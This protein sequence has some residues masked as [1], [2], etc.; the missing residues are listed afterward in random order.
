M[1]AVVLLAL[2]ALPL[3]AQDQELKPI[4]QIQG[5]EEYK[6]P[7]GL[8]IVLVPDATKPTL[9]MNLTV[10]VG[11]VH[12][13]GGEAGMAHVFEHILFHSAEGFPDITETLKNLGANY[14]GS[15]SYERTN[16]FET[17]NATD[18][19]LETVIKL[20]AARLSKADLKPEDLEKEGKIVENEFDIGESSPQGLLFKAFMGAMYDYHNYGR[21]PIGTVDDFRALKIDAIRAFYK[22]YYRPDNAVVI[23]TGKFERAKALGLI[24]KHFG[25][26]K[27]TGEGRPVYTTREP[28]ARGERRVTVRKT[29]DSRLVLIGYRIPGASSPESPVATVLGNMLASGKTGPLYEAVVGKGLAASL[30]VGSYDLRTASPFLGLAMLPKDKDPDAVESTM[31]EYFEKKIDALTQADLDRAKSTLDRDFDELLNDPEALGTQLSEYE[32]AGS[33]KI[34]LIQRELAK[35]VTLDDVKKFAVKYLRSENRVVARFEPDEKAASV[36]PDTEPDLSAYADLLSKM[37]ATVK[38]VKEFD[39]APSAIQTSLQWTAAGPAKIGV[40]TKEVKGDDVFVEFGIPLAGRA[41][42]RE[43]IAAGEALAGV[44]TERTKSM[45]KSETAKKLAEWKASIGVSISLDRASVSIR[46]KKDTLKDVMALATEMLRAPFITEE[47]LKEYVTKAEGQIKARKDNPMMLVMEELPKVVF[48]PSD[49]RRGPSPEE[50]LEDLKKLSL[51]ALHKFHRD[52]LGADG[53]LAGVVGQ[54]SLDEAARLFGPLVRDWKANTPFTIERNDAVEKVAEEKRRVETPGKPAAFSILLQP[55]RLSAD[56]P[57]YPALDAATWVLFQ[58]PLSSRIP[59]RVREQEAL[60]YMTIGQVLCRLNGDFALIAIFSQ[61]KPEKAE[62]AIG[63]IRDELAKALKDG[64]TAEE[65]KSYTKSY[66]SRMVQQ[67]SQDAVLAGSIPELQRWGLDFTLWA[68][69]DAAVER[70][71]LDDVNAAMRKFVRPGKMGL[72]QIGDFK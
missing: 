41:K 5:I 19:N 40:I 55:M 52:Y 57:E 67:R 39:Y 58:D 51:E 42:I 62:T 65:L 11:S 16:Y 36:I 17:V 27:G 69:Q 54:V 7:N 53:M 60:S 70:L 26:F 23:L 66:R 34:L 22:R 68:K 48:S 8:R 43:S 25:G 10:L 28:A 49:P 9:T 47:Q 37:P 24:Q 1:R 38:A 56:S 3:L 13:G 59:K 30:F 4:A 64:I 29:G 6:L 71:T 63:F 33:W 45:D 2:A 35:K 61:T 15:T 18:E 14:N 32:A 72:L 12:E 21:S 20:E 50:R 44:L 31:I 46:A